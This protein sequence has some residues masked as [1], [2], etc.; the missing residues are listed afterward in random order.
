MNQLH[1]LGLRTLRKVREMTL[2]HLGQC[3]QEWRLAGT[4]VSLLEAL[5]APEACHLHLQQMCYAY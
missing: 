2:I 4:S 3:E 1:I 5:L